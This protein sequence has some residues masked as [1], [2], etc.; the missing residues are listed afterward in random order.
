MLTKWTWNDHTCL[1]IFDG[2]DKLNILIT[3][4]ERVDVSHNTSLLSDGVLACGT[5]FIYTTVQPDQHDPL[6]RPDVIASTGTCTFD[7]VHRSLC[8]C[9]HCEIAQKILVKI[10]SELG[11][12]WS[13]NFHSEFFS[14]LF[15][16]IAKQHLFLYCWIRCCGKEEISTETF[17]ISKKEYWSVIMVVE[18]RT[19]HEKESFFF[20]NGERS[21]DGI[22]PFDYELFMLKNSKMEYF[23]LPNTCW[24]NYLI[25]EDLWLNFHKS[26]ISASEATYS[27]VQKN[28]HIFFYRDHC[29]SKSSFNFF[30]LWLIVQSTIEPH[31]LIFLCSSSEETEN[32]YFLFLGKAELFVIQIWIF[33][34]SSFENVRVHQLLF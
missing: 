29:I 6:Y 16:F 5:N 31:N 10:W 19:I 14:L 12:L 22:F 28:L 20:F 13:I 24:I 9:C 26:I 1:G 30:L 8:R 17:V 18:K 34:T 2:I 11:L 4:C 15:F 25:N 7:F 21:F 33:L 32:E 3:I 27:C 23:I